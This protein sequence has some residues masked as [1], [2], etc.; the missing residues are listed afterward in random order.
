MRSR[1]QGGVAL[2]AAL[3]AAA[4][5][6]GA[7]GAQRIAPLPKPCHVDGTELLRL[8]QRIPGSLAVSIFAS[9]STDADGELA[10]GI[11]DAV[12]NR[13]GTAI[14]RILVIGRRAQRRLVVVDSLTARAMA[15]S[16][17]AA[18]VLAGRVSE[19]IRG[20]T[21]GFTLYNGVTGR[22]LM[23]R[24]L[25]HDSAHVMLV[26]QNVS[27]QVASQILGKLKPQEQR[28]LERVPDVNSKAYDLYVRGQGA[29]DVWNFGQAAD[30]FR[31]ATRLAR[32][33]A[34]AYAE[35]ALADAEV[36]HRGVNSTLAADILFELR[37]A[38]SHAIALDSTS[39][40]SWRAEAQSRLAQGRQAALWRRA[41]ERAI[42]ADPRDPAAF[43]D[44]GIALI[45]TGDRE[46]GRAMLARALALEPGRAQP[47]A[48]LASLAVA[49][50]RDGSACTL[51]NEAIVG[52]VLF[53][54]AW[55]QRAVVRA[56][57]GD[58]RFAWADAETATQLG[59]SHLGESAGAMVDLIARDTSRARDRLN[60]EWTQVKSAG[61]VGVLDG[62]SIARALLA[63]GQSNRALDVL[64]L[65]MPRGP[66]LLAALRDPAFDSIRNDK[67]FRA[68]T[69]G[70]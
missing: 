41:Y 39:S 61:T 65:A 20:R 63:A 37:S 8:P 35:L 64:E 58:L 7:A 18:Y 12:A 53:A 15:D 3:V 45:R 6:P 25:R 5:I 48:A 10:G 17:G 54:P 47:I 62:T 4:L 34:P 43:E 33:F 50:H 42:A 9:D 36:L 66:W 49:D 69:S 59:A 52:D 27:G 57:H 23:Y 44:Y 67:R 21:V 40:V 29:R 31:Q 38:A 30:Y 24:T 55:A 32:S 70:P 46:A 22:A 2:A 1:A 14:P 60:V 68:I 19:G 11:A 56:R 28:A 16:L 26:E 51:L 13:I